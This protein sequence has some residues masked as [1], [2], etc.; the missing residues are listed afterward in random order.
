MRNKY[1]R[2]AAAL[3]A[4]AA[5]GL[6]AFALRPSAKPSGRTG[7]QQ[8]RGAGANAGDPPHRPHRAPRGGR[9]NR[10]GPR[11]RRFTWPRRPREDRS[12]RLPSR[13]GR[14][15]RRRRHTRERLRI[16]VLRC[17]VR[18]RRRGNADERLRRRVILGLQ[19]LGQRPRD[20]NQPRPLEQRLKRRRRLRKCT[21]HAHELGRL[22]RWLGRIWK[23]SGHPQQWWRRWRRQPWRRG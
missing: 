5:G 16:G 1:T 2:I 15:W 17:I 18:R 10:L 14:R 6:A 3:A 23:P 12:Q 7:S 20:A 19:R 9:R 22:E 21:D 13:L 11:R 8:P 4:I